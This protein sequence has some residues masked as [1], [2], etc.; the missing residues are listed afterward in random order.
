MLVDGTK[1]EN[2]K[3]QHFHICCSSLCLNK[4]FVINMWLSQNMTST[5]CMGKSCFH[6]NERNIIKALN[7]GL[8][9]NKT[10]IVY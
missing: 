8:I 2:D 9:M 5:I 3:E 4:S 1:H 6:M 10:Y 7:N